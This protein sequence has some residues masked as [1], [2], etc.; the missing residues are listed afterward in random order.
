[1]SSFSLLVKG[2]NPLREGRHPSCSGR[3]YGLLLSP[4]GVGRPRL[5]NGVWD[6][7]QAATGAPAVAS[8]PCSCGH[9]IPFFESDALL[10]F[11]NQSTGGSQERVCRLY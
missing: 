10:V 5:D 1:M 2:R 3:L 9:P 6:L 8:L 4:A 11:L 7:R